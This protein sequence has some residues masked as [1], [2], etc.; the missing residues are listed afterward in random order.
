MKRKFS[1]TFVWSQKSDTMV[2]VFLATR[3]PAR[4]KAIYTSSP[5]VLS[6]CVRAREMSAD[7]KCMRSETKEQ[8]RTLHWQHQATTAVSLA[9]LI[10][11]I[12]KVGPAAHLFTSQNG[13][14]RTKCHT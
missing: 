7:E 14:D 2:D 9:T 10:E 6:M 8:M 1:K 3:R 12:L 5:P 11:N 13:S 4:G